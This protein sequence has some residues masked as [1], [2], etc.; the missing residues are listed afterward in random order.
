MSLLLD[1]ATRSS[2][3]LLL[4]FVAVALLRRRSAALRHA[5][6]AS[7]M[8]AGG[9]IVPVGMYQPLWQLHVALP[10][11]AIERSRADGVPQVSSHAAT[12][13][14]A[15]A[16]ERRA[17][18]SPFI[19]LWAI[20]LLGCVAWL[21]AGLIRLARATG[22][23][24]PVGDARWLAAARHVGG[25]RV[26][27][28]LAILQTD[29]PGLLATWGV[30]RPVVLIP[31]QATGWSDRRIRAVLAHE[32]AHIRRRDWLV[33][34]LVELLSAIHWY[35]PLV[36]V[37]CTR[38]RRESERA[39][40]DAVLEDG[41]PAREYAE[42]LLEIA[43]TC[44]RSGTRWA[45]AITMARQSTLERRIGAMLNPHTCRS[46]LSRRVVAATATVAL[47]LAV[48]IAVLRASPM[49]PLPLTGIVYD[50][51]G[52]VLPGV[53]LTLEGAGGV[54]WQTET[55]SDGRFAFPPVEPGRYGFELRLIGFRSLRHEVELRSAQDWDRAITLQVGELV[56]TVSV[57]ATRVEAPPAAAPQMPTP[58]LVRVGGNIKAP[59]KTVHVSPIYPA[60]MRNA[61]REGRVSIDAII[62]TDGRVLAARVMGAHTH[63]DFADAALEAVRQ[64]LF[65]PTLLNGIPVEV[66]MT[67]RVHFSLAD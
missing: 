5:V 53:K 1:V 42:H 9:V 14:D 64:W 39:A 41:V 45:P 21:A 63:P 27:K 11:A 38:L 51:S 26:S 52:G 65:T 7:A 47:G 31:P 58:Q 8:F 62:D 20:G 54:A 67:V 23:A 19:T 66:R 3:V 18:V 30:R 22:R 43:R 29:A 50:V 32:L 15:E 40:D 34:V 4:G 59:S 56:E 57:Q 48:P 33:Q 44:R 6:L 17:V 49:Q 24:R 28:R 16:V 60:S 55:G 10:A 12:A 35:N 46:A 25:S 2:A 13:M 36:W 61:G 37:A